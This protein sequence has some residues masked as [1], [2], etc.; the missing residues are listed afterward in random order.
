[1]LLFSCGQ[2][3]GGHGRSRETQRESEAEWKEYRD[4]ARA[5]ARGG[6]YF[7]AEW[8]LYFQT[9]EEL[10]AHYEEVSFAVERS[11]LIVTRRISTGYEP[12]FTNSAA[13]DLV[14]CVSNSF[15]NKNVVVADVALATRSWEDVANVRFRY[16][17]A[18]DSSCDQNNG[19]VAFAV[20]PTTISGLAGC[21][22][23]KLVWDESLA[24]MGC[25]VGGGRVKGVLLVNYGEFPSSDPLFDLVTPTGAWR[26]ELGHILGFRHEQP[27]RPGGCN[28]GEVADY[29]QY[30][31]TGRQL[32]SY[33]V[34]SIM[35][36]PYCGGTNETLE[37]LSPADGDGA[38]SIYGM[39]ASWYVA[40]RI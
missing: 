17:S 30:D 32:T 33:D 19:V 27:W 13:T 21:G 16:D 10:R 1:M 28:D 25:P 35:H 20:M 11:L 22:S 4:A 18:Q 8:D 36:Y 2:G 40:L 37:L 31:L 38:R 5:A 29:P 34:A 9:E 3:A 12:V 15:T 7:I 14:Y 26:H 6:D 39:P 23:S 24:R